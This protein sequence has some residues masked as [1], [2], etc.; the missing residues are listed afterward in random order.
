M[1]FRS[2][3]GNVTAAYF[4]TSGGYGNISQVDTITANVGV[5][6]GNITV[7]GSA[8]VIMPNRPAFRVNGTGII[9]Q[10]L[11][12]NVNLKGAAITTIFNQG[13]YFDA[14]TGKFTAP[15]AGIYNVSLVAR[16]AD[17]NGL[18]QIAV[19]KN[20]NNSSGNVVCFW[21]TDTNT[22]VSTHFGTSGTIQLAV[23]DYLS[24]NILA[25][26]ITFDGNDN[27]CVTYLG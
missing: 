26:N 23:G 6:S 27:W 10:K 22:G 24:A 15:V 8:G 19:L 16:V 2:A 1:L 5:Y 20:G 9:A 14:T 13:S 4:V 3:T 21:E 18:N 7:S 17:Y 11:S 25:G 12:P